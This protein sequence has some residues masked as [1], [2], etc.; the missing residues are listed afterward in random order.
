MLYNVD[1]ELT[2]AIFVVGKK[3]VRVLIHVILHLF[4]NT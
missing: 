2:I 4:I 1:V 3:A